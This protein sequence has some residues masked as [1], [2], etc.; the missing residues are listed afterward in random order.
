[1]ILQRKA[2][3]IRHNLYFAALDG[4]MCRALHAVIT[5]TDR[6]DGAG[7]AVDG[8]TIEPDADLMRHTQAMLA[9]LDYSGI[10]CAQFLVDEDSGV[11]SFLE[12]NPR[13]AGNHA[14]PQHCGLDLGHFLV[15]LSRGERDGLADG[16]MRIGRAG[17]RYSWLAGDIDGLKSSLKRREISL[18]QAWSWLGKLIDTARGAELDMMLSRDD[19]LPGI[20]TLLD[21]IPGIGHITRR[22]NAL[23]WLTRKRA[24]E[25]PKAPLLPIA[26]LAQR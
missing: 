4:V 16:D 26:P 22:R 5:R 21:V 23:G 9:E 14:V 11:V 10:G 3:G 19:R 13:I 18:L 6:I 17:V 2:Q 1:M 15:A 24:I 25:A 7:L 12:I 20:I 8:I